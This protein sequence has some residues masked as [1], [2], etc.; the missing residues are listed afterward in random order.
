MSTI[1]PANIVVHDSNE[2]RRIERCRCINYSGSPNKLMCKAHLAAKPQR[3]ASLQRLY[4]TA[5][6][7]RYM[8]HAHSLV[9]ALAQLD[10]VCS[11]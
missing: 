7:E 9:F 1:V 8:R 2:L 3:L 5:H 11:S 10:I 4:R 6:R